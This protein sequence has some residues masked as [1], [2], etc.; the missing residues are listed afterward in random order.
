MAS[1]IAISEVHVRVGHGKY[2]SVR[3]H[4]LVRSG[5]GVG[6]ATEGPQYQA[7]RQHS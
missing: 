5:L 4:T 2:Q 1:T 6:V 7:G 3:L